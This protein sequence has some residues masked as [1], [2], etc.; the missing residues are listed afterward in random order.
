MPSLAPSSLT[1]NLVLSS[2]VCS[3]QQLCSHWHSQLWHSSIRSVTP[4]LCMCTLAQSVFTVLTFPTSIWSDPRFR[5]LFTMEKGKTML[6]D[7]HSKWQCFT[8]ALIYR[9]HR[10]RVGLIQLM[11]LPRSCH[12]SAVFGSYTIA[13]YFLSLASVATL[14]RVLITIG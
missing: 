10:A 6:M 2:R 11:R 13:S 8:N 3:H 7:Y 14:R 1:G 12:S 5:R 9:G 4:A